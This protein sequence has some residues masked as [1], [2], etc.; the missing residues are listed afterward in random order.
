MK[1]LQPVAG[2]QH[3]KGFTLLELLLALAVF[4]LV[5]LAAS[6][7]L[8]AMLDGR[9][10]Y[11][12]RSSDLNQTEL[13]FTLLEKDLAQLANNRLRDLSGD[14][15]DGP[16]RFSALDEQM[17]W[18]THNAW[19]KEVS[20]D[21]P[22]ITRVAW[23]WKD[24]ALTRTA[25]PLRNPSEPA[26]EPEMLMPIKSLEWGFYHGDRW[27][28]YPPVDGTLPQA[29]SLTLETDTLGKVLRRFL[30][31]EPVQTRNTDQDDEEGEP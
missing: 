9:E 27:L 14:F 12:V 28:A 7:T 24:A 8:S 17:E 25:V 18:L 11:Q 15:L 21:S 26:I 23:G 16:W 6:T 29:I 10:N 4:A 30:L 1:N 19:M 5:G 20:P 22:S 13:A 31:P 3:S 2:Y